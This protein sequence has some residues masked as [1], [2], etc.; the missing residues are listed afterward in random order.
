M[1]PIVF[2]IHLAEQM[3]PDNLDVV[4]CIFFLIF[5]FH[6]FQVSILKVYYENFV[7]DLNMNQL[8][9]QSMNHPAS[10]EFWHNCRSFFPPWHFLHTSYVRDL[11]QPR[12]VLG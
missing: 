3:Q 7:L 4:L 6:L 2:L 12:S 5:R 1:F 9:N 10:S 8:M 11:R